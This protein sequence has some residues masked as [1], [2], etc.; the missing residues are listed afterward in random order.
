MDLAHPWRTLR[1]LAHI[2]VTWCELPHGYRALTDGRSRI[3][4]H[5]RLLQRERRA[6][7]QH[8]L[9]HIRAGHVGCQPP[10]TEAKIRF[11]AAMALLPDLD[12][13]LDELVFYSG[14]MEA[15]AVDL[16]VD[17]ATVAA[18]LDPA[19]THPAEKARIR[20]RLEGE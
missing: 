9:E 7:L 19:Y 1:A 11:D 10:R 2:T 5:K 20:E 15:A 12:Q 8:E 18:R 16:W 3:W 4:M 17:A 6:S 13:V 14:D